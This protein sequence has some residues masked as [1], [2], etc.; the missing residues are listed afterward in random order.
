MPI[1]I[2]FCTFSYFLCTIS[3]ISVRHN[4]FPLPSNI[5]H[6]TSDTSPLPSSFFHLSFIPNLLRPKNQTSLACLPHCGQKRYEQ[7]C[8]MALSNGILYRLNNIP[9]ILIRYIRPSRQAH[10]HLEDFFRHAID[11]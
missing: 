5:F 1:F 3:T 10:T 9:H 11:I 7:N 4:I 2:H 8:Q 6:H